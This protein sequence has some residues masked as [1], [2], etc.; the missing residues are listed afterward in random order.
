MTSCY[1]GSVGDVVARFHS[2]SLREQMEG[3]VVLVLWDLCSVCVNLQRPQPPAG[4]AGQN[5]RTQLRLA[6][7][8][9]SIIQF[10]LTGSGD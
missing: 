2:I 5:V 3:S 7:G 6:S 10:A 4:N 1:S 8:K 9:S